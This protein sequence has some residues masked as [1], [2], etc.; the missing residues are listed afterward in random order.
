MFELHVAVAVVLMFNIL[1]L[2][3][4]IMSNYPKKGA[5]R[6][7]L[8]VKTETHLCLLC[9]GAGGGATTP[10]MTA[11]RVVRGG[12]WFVQV[13]NCTVGVLVRV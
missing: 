7:V 3:L 11:A 8:A 9:T 6:S 5:T 4:K 2:I 12:R 1:E 10:A 13:E